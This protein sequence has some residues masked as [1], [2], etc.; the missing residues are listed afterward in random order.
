M[1]SSCVTP[2]AEVVIICEGDMLWRSGSPLRP[3]R[4]FSK[5]AQSR[6]CSGDSRPE[7]FSTRRPH[8]LGDRI[9]FDGAQYGFRS[10]VF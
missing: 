7:R 5:G 4:A 6:W 3:L 9:L 8:T 2:D 1:T 10:L